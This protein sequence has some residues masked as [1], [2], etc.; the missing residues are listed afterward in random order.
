MKIEIEDIIFGILALILLGVWYLTLL[1]FDSP[2]MS[3][4]IL[5]TAMTLLSILYYFVYKKRNRDMKILRKRFYISAIPIYP[6][7]FYYFYKLVIDHDLPKEQEF[8]PFFIVFSVLILNAIILYV[9]EI[10]EKD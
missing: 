5:W 10:R 3:I 2:L 6:M 9:Y 1:I 8:L 4:I 7:L